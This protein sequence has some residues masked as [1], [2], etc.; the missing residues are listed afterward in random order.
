MHVTVSS[1]GMT[2]TTTTKYLTQVLL[3]Q[4]DNG[5]GHGVF[6]WG[7]TFNEFSEMRESDKSLKRESGSI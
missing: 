5:T 2:K 7:R 6:P 1:Q 3:I 4:N